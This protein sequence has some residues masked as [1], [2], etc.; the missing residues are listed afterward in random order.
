MIAMADEV[1][2]DRSVVRYVRQLAEASRVLPQVRM[3]LSARGCLA[4]VRAA[5]TWAAAEG[6]G[7]VVPHDIVTLAEPILGHRLLLDVQ[8]QFSGVQVAD[9]VASLLEQVSPPVDRS[10]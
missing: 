6:R 1:Y 10:D 2:V 3:G 4:F 7:H 9:V 8:A 5:K